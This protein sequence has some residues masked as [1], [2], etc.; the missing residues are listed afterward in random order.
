MFI[1]RL[2]YYSLLNTSIYFMEN[3]SSHDGYGKVLWLHGFWTW[4]SSESAMLAIPFSSLS[5][6]KLRGTVLSLIVYSELPQSGVCIAF[7]RRL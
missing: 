1:L 5:I 3:D 6:F 7:M 2:C 4:S